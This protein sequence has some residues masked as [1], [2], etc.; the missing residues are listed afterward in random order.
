MLAPLEK[1]GVT[2]IRKALNKER[3]KVL[4]A[5]D[6]LPASA[7]SQ[8]RR[9]DR[10]RFYSR[11]FGL[12][13]EHEAVR[14]EMMDRVAVFISSIDE[15]LL[16]TRYNENHD[17]AGRFATKEGGSGKSSKKKDSGGS[18]GGSGGGSEDGDSS[19]LAAKIKN[20]PTLDYEGGGW[21]K[22]Y[23]VKGGNALILTDGKVAGGSIYEHHNVIASDVDPNK[24]L[25]GMIASGVVR[26]EIAEGQTEIGLE[27]RIDNK[28]ARGHASAFLRDNYKGKQDTDIF[29]DVQFAGT[30]EDY[31]RIR[32][33][34]FTGSSAYLD[35]QKFILTFDPKKPNSYKR[36][37]GLIAP[38]FLLGEWQTRYNENHD[39]AGRF[40]TKEGG[41]ASSKKSDGGDSG[42]GGGGLSESTKKTDTSHLVDVAKQGGFTWDVNSKR[43]VIDEL[44]KV[45]S[46]YPNLSLGIKTEKLTGDDIARYAMKNWEKLHEPNHFLGAWRD[47]TTGKTFLDVSITVKSHDEATRLATIHD[48]NSY[49]DVGTGTVVVVNEHATSGG[50]RS[51]ILDGE[52]D[53]GEEESTTPFGNSGGAYGRGSRRDVQVADGQGM[54]EGRLGVNQKDLGRGEEET[55]LELR[56][57]AADLEREIAKILEE[58]AKIDSTLNTKIVGEQNTAGPLVQADNQYMKW[59]A[60]NFNPDVIKQTMMPIVIDGYKIGATAS[61]GMLFKLGVADKETLDVA[62]SRLPK[63]A[64][65]FIDSRTGELTKAGNRTKEAVRDALFFGWGKGKDHIP[66]WTEGGNLSDLKDAVR[67]AFNQEMSFNRA[68][69]IARTEVNIAQNTGRFNELRAEGVKKKQWLN[70]G[71]EHV[72]ESHVAAANDGPIPMDEPFSNGLMNPGDPDGPPEEVI[73]CFLPNTKIAGSIVGALEAPYAGPAIEVVTRK[74]YRLSVTPNHPVLSLTG[75]VPVKS[76]YVGDKLVTYNFEIDNAGANQDD[77]GSSVKDIFDSIGGHESIVQSGPMDFHGDG[78]FVKQQINIHSRY[79]RLLNDRDFLCSDESGK[80]FFVLADSAGRPNTSG[81]I[82]LSPLL[83]AQGAPLQALRFGPSA[84]LDTHLLKSSIDGMAGDPQ[85]GCNLF[86][87]LPGEESSLDVVN[88]QIP[89]LPGRTPGSSKVSPQGRLSDTKLVRKLI[90]RFP[91]IVSLDEIIEVRNFYFT[92]HVYDLQSE[93]GYVVANGIASRQCRCTLVPV[94]DDEDLA[95]IAEAEA[96]LAEELQSSD[97]SQAEDLELQGPIESPTEAP[98]DDAIMGVLPELNDSLKPLLFETESEQNLR[99]VESELLTAGGDFDKLF[100]QHY[101]LQQKINDILDDPSRIAFT[102]MGEQEH[103][104]PSLWQARVEAL[105]GQQNEIENL[106]KEKKDLLD[107]LR[108]KQEELQG[109]VKEEQRQALAKRIGTG[110]LG[111]DG[112]GASYAGSTGGITD[113]AIRAHQRAEDFIKNVVNSKIIVDGLDVTYYPKGGLRASYNAAGRELNLSDPTMGSGGENVTATIVHELGHALEHQSPHVHE[114]AVEFLLKR[115]KESG[116]A[117]KQIADMTGDRYESHELAIDDKFT[118]PYA[119]KLYVKYHYGEADAYPGPV[120]EWPK[121]SFESTEVVSMGM[122]RLYENP[123]RFAK[124]DPEY[125]AFIVGLIQG[126]L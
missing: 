112:F 47:N 119:G 43:L 25:G 1:R 63:L 92:G 97:K 62:T 41:G 40:A 111:S 65:T 9:A 33:E 75:S 49:Y 66:G 103:T 19:D 99:D 89:T 67:K 5:L 31:T 20:A 56:V 2:A 64:K 39:D 57:T 82:S 102:K 38:R 18:G 120:W 50:Q 29:I 24:T 74:G 7:F 59:V 61:R 46:P 122:Q 98:L 35:A 10:E 91:T 90:E 117:V 106:M 55:R 125:F 54:L 96:A 34:S 8:K 126:D 123:R 107:E 58:I 14:R 68:R 16:E 17:D 95:I 72:R 15:G 80:L 53:G 6:Q 48:Q 88:A 101:D 30:D 118:D 100:T 45:V 114:R 94:L 87:T 116:A 28:T 124:D 51:F 27:F 70:A 23:A 4:A 60:N 44:A 86:D 52:D 32:N 115:A 77:V 79:A 37:F 21:R 22:E 93:T 12:I 83:D 69:T 78:E 81:C 104:E 3:K 13:V 121:D 109:L 36:S 11:I 108:R 110:R 113:N 84:W 73:N 42:G 85:V 105:R 71:D 76:L 26:A